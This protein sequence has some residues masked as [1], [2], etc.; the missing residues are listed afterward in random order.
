M[1][2]AKSANKKM[3][4]LPSGY[5]A[6]TSGG[7]SWDYKTN[8]ILEGKIV[9]F[10][11]VQ[12]TKYFEKVNGKKVPKEQ[13]VCDLE[14]SD[15]RVS[16]FESAALSALYDLKEG[17]RVCVVFQGLKKIANRDKPM[18]LFSVGVKK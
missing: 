15:G 11:T 3:I 7:S 13:R 6:I 8:P 5:T 18:K 17:T 4:E 12:S 9:G 10:R 1:A 2:R 16:V 14:T